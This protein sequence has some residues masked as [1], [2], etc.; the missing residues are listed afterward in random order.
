[1]RWKKDELEQ[2]LS[3]KE[4]IDTMIIPLLPFQLSQDSDVTK[5]AFQREVLEAFS[6]ELEQELTGRVILT[7]TYNYLKTADK[8]SEIDRI[9]TWTE[10]MNSQPVNHVF[11]T[12]FDSSWKKVEQAVPGT[13]LWI[14]GITD[15]EIDSKEMQRLIRSQVEQ[16]SELIRTY[17]AE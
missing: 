7:P 9:N 11:F 1:M 4:Y 10:D 16:V 8:Q 12:T 3:A 15:G 2:Y 14:P 13:L 5:D 17:W 6:T